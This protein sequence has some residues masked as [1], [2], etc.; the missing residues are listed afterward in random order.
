[1]NRSPSRRIIVCL[2]RAH[3]IGDL[4]AG[5]QSAATSDASAAVSTSPARARRM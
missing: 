4:L 3:Q 5:G 2:G 1:V